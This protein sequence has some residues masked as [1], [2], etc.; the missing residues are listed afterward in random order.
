[1][2]IAAIILLLFRSQELIAGLGGNPHL[3][4]VVVQLAK[5]YS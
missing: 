2:I 4:A 5:L 1:M 3:S